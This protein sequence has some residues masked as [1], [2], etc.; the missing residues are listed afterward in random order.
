MSNMKSCKICNATKYEMFQN[1]NVTKYERSQKNKKNITK[2]ET[3]K[4]LIIT[5]Y[6]PH[7]L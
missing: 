7:K 3:F 5:K 2:Y 1:I 4:H 6:D